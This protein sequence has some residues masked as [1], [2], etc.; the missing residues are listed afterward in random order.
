MNGK[1]PFV[2]TKRSSIWMAPLQQVRKLSA[3]FMSREAV[4]NPAYRVLN[5]VTR[6]VNNPYYKIMIHA[7]RLKGTIIPSIGPVIFAV[8]IESVIVAVL[9]LRYQLP[10][11]L[12][13]RMISMMGSAI[14]MLLA[15]RTN[16]SFERYN[17][18]S[19]LWTNL[20]SQIRHSARLLWTNITPK[21]E[22]A[23]NEKMQIMKLLLATAVA[24]KYALRGVD[25]YNFKDLVQLLADDYE[26]HDTADSLRLKKK[27]LSASVSNMGSSP[28]LFSETITKDPLQAMNK[29][30]LN[31][32]RVRPMSTV[33]PTL[34]KYT[35][36][37]D[38]FQSKNKSHRPLSFQGSMPTS[39]FSKSSQ[40]YQMPASLQ[41]RCIGNVIN[42]PLD[43]LHHINKYVRLQCKS[44]T[45]ASEDVPP[46]TSAISIAIESVT[47]FE[48]ILYFPLP[49][50]YDIHLKHVLLLYFLLLPLQLVKSMG[51]SMIL[52]TF[53]MSLTFFGTD[54]IAGEISDPFG[55]DENDLPLDYFCQK[56][57]DD[58]EYIM[59]KA[60]DGDVLEDDDGIKRAERTSERL[61]DEEDET[62]DSTCMRKSLVRV[63]TFPVA[64]NGHAIN[65]RKRN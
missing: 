10:I 34:P 9:F 50:T 64:T 49:A 8:F 17:Q 43:I 59:D 2:I 25:P 40:R 54:A 62:D 4:H 37:P 58:I 29:I 22:A 55:N 18:G 5:S 19:Q 38:T 32:E 30:C 35:S 47:K 26:T 60:F 61:Y 23:Q 56:L 13:D 51:Y 53:I 12:D 41:R 21:T 65:L 42:V 57:R 1:H 15:F 39:K 16:R 46:T 31:Q 24:T 20:S 63:A 7:F 27:A 3:H 33:T 36:E 44:G 6:N 11:N 14:A 52:A 45:L 48:Q 28:T